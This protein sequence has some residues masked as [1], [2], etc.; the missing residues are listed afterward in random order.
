MQI[1]I[2]GSTGLIGTALVRALRGEGRTVLRL[3]RRRP[4]ADDEIR[5]DPFGEVDTASLE[6]VDAVVHLAGAGIGD[7]RWSDCYKQ[8]IRDSRVEGTRTLSRA[9]AALRDGPAVLVSG[10]ASGYYGDTGDRTVDEDSPS[11]EGFLAALCRDWEAA[12]APAAEAGIRVVLPR[13]GV[14]L[15]REGGA[16][17]RLLPVFR[18]GLG[19]R[20]G[21]GRQWM[22]WISL[23]DQIAAL[24]FLIDGDVAGPVNL[25]APAPVT[26]AAYTA[27]VGRA[28][29][30]PTFFAVPAAVLR[31][32]LGGLADEGALVSQRIMPARLTAAGFR[33]QHPDLDTALADL[34]P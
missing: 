32:A 27:A 5:W 8:E 2:T 25:T 17:G 33:F 18:A 24:R 7:R 15:A 13:A 16:L 6:G 14:V 30:R 26:N 4:S 31:L 29:H 34:L 1:A 23:T 19:G 21:S 11:G 3:V 10:S 12:T 22:S 28:L 20:L 9:L